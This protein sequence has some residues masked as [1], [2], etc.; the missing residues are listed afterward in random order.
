VR[1]DEAPPAHGLPPPASFAGPSL[2]GVTVLLVDADEAA[3]AATGGLLRERGA[4]VTQAS[5]AGQALEIVRRV[6]PDVLL[7]R[8]NAESEICHR[9]IRAVREIPPGRG[10]LTPAAVFGAGGALQERMKS[11]MAG[12]QAHLPAPVTGAELATV[13]ASLAGRTRELL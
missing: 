5:S 7:A 9:L 2:E 13:V 3:A 6:R 11:L 10:G 4:E 12:Y 1:L 8:G